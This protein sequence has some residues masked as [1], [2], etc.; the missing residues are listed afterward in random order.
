VQYGVARQVA[1]RPS[2]MAPKRP[3]FFSRLRRTL[4]TAF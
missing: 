4:A 1:D 3:G 2:E